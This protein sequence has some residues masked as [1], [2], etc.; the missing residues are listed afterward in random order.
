MVLYFTFFFDT[1]A[2][3][4]IDIMKHWSSSEMTFNIDF[5]FAG[6]SLYISIILCKNFFTTW[7]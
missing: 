6:N 2:N 5:D 3:R 7:H 4:S 1:R